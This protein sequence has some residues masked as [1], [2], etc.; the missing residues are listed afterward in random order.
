MIVNI[1]IDGAVL[2]QNEDGDPYWA[3]ETIALEADTTGNILCFTCNTCKD[4]FE[5]RLNPYDLLRA[6]RKLELI[7]FDE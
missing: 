7:G 6:M 5:L 3:D 2:S 4:K 1:L